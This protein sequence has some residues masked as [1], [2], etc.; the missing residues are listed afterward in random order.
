MPQVVYKLKKNLLSHLNKPATYIKLSEQ[1][2]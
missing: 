1:V 2:H